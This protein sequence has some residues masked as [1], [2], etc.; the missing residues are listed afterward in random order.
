MQT[1]EESSIDQMLTSW[2]RKRR[3]GTVEKFSNIFKDIKFEFKRQCS[4]ADDTSM[5]PIW[6]NALRTFDISNHTVLAMFVIVST[7]LWSIYA[8]TNSFCR[9]LTTAKLCVDH[10][11]YCTVSYH[12]NAPRRI[13]SHCN[14]NMRILQCFH[15]L[16]FDFYALTIAHVPVYGLQLSTLGGHNH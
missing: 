13:E 14:G 6:L 4:M 15:L 16:L 3:I 7:T 12:G 10:I 8:S 2:P 5:D 11:G 1:R 9:L